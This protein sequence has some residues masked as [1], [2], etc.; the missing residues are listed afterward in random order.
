MRIALPVIPAQF[1]ALELTVA[2]GIELIE[3]PLM[4]VHILFPG[5]HAIPV[6]IH[7]AHQSLLAG[8]RGATLCKGGVRSASKD[9]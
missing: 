2:I 6:S 5:H 3:P 8:L 7:L 1:V 9:E 4:V